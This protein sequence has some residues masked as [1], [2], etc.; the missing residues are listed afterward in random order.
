[1]GHGRG[2]AFESAE[3]IWEEVRTV[4]P[5]GAGIS[6]RR[7]DR[8]GLQ[9]PCPSEDHPGTTV[10]HEKEFASG[11][12]AALRCIEHAPTSE[13]VSP[14]FPF[15]LGTGRS[16]YQFNAGTMTMRTRNRELRP[17]DR[18]DMSPSDGERLALQEGDRVRVRSR[19]G[20]A[21]MPLHLDEAI[22]AGHLFATF[23]DPRTWLNAVTG[24]VRDTHTGAPEYKVT[25][26]RVDRA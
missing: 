3:Q 11:P 15:V 17:T 9:W 24:V 12:T 19:Y 20:E 22:P 2:F 8:E 14:E 23:S 16:L 5:D 6:Y 4:W 1:M 13:Q 10:L 25:A 26:V 18:L 21:E 7:L